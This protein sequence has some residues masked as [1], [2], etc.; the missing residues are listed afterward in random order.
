VQL[1]SVG[2][3]LPVC[4]NAWVGVNA[5]VDPTAAPVIANEPAAISRNDFRNLTGSPQNKQ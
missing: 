3:G 2:L 5:I 4:A 1:D